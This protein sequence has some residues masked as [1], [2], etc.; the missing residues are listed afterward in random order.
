MAGPMYGPY[1]KWGYSSS[2]RYVRKYRR[3]RGKDFLVVES[4]TKISSSSVYIWLT[5]CYLIY[6][7]LGATGSKHLGNWKIRVWV[8]FRLYLHIGCAFMKLRGKPFFWAKFLVVIWSK[9]PLVRCVDAFEGIE[10][11]RCG[12]VED[13]CRRK[14]DGSIARCQAGCLIDQRWKIHLQQSNFAS[15][16]NVHPHNLCCFQGGLKMEAGSEYNF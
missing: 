10:G 14:R 13:W 7:Q 11:W 1:W 3:V 16:K 9:A 2:D 15:N 5:D 4:Y 12:T 6:W 8:K